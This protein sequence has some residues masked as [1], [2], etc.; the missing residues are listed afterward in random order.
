MKNILY[1]SLLSACLFI[2][3]G[4]SSCTKTPLVIDYTI[5][6]MQSCLNLTSTQSYHIDTFTV[7]HSAIVSAISNAGV[8]DLSRVTSVGLKQM[9]VVGVGSANFDQ[10]SGVEVYYVNTNV[11]ANVT[12]CAYGNGGTAAGVTQFSLLING[13]DLTQML[14]SDGLLIVKVLN[15]ANGNPAMCLKVTQGI[16]ETNVRND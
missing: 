12:Q 8:K 2:L 15:K 3:I 6:D 9:Q 11:P 14:Y 5:S 10:V 7:S 1:S 13:A 4:V 16:I